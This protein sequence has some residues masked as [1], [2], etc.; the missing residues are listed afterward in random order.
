MVAEDDGLCQGREGAHG[1]ALAE[2][3]DEIWVFL[4]ESV[5]GEEEF[6][7]IGVVRREDVRKWL[8]GRGLEKEEVDE[9]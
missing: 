5:F 6:V 8:C 4:G 9:G 2:I 7:C 3:V 1:E